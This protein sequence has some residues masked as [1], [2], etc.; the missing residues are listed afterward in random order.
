MSTRKWDA[1]LQAYRDAR[2]Q[3][4]QPASTKMKDIKA[5]VAASNHFGSAFK[6]DEPGRGII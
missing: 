4:I 5:A 6:A 1:E 3:G 2:S